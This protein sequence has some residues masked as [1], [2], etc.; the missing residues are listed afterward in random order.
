MSRK[1]IIV[2][3]VAF[4]RPLIE[5]RTMLESTVVKPDTVTTLSKDPLISVLRRFLNGC[6]DAS[7]INEWANMLEGLIFATDEV[8]FPEEGGE[9]LRKALYR[10][11]NPYLFG[12]L[13]AERARGLIASLEQGM[14]CE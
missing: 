10:I 7:E 3:L 11:S 12:P 6:L 13:T 4:D 8:D 1:A 5:L 2:A 9:L 14:L